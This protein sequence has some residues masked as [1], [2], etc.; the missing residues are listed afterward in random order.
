MS[1]LLPKNGCIE[2]ES[3]NKSCLG[4]FEGNIM[5]CNKYEKRE[6]LEIECVDII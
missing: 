4:C 5:G 1:G 6:R 3:F 2:H